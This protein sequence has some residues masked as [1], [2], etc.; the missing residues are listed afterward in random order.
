[1]G[2][3]WAIGIDVGG[4][5]I[6]AGLVGFPSGTVLERQIVS[7]EPRRGG[8]AVLDDALSMARTLLEKAAARKLEPAGIG[9]GVAELVDLGGNIT[10][11][12]NIPW[13]GLP[14]R[15]AFDLLA[16]AV[17]ESDVRAAARGEALLGAGQSFRVFAYLTVGTGISACLVQDGHPYAGARGNA[18][19]LASGTYG[20]ECPHCGAWA[21]RVLED[22]AA[23]GAL[24]ARY[25]RDSTQAEEVLAAAAAGDE[26]A[27]VVVTSAGRALGQAVG[28]LV[29]LLDPEALIVGGGLGLAGG[30]YWTSLV[31]TLRPAVWSPSTR[32]LAVLPARLGVDAGL[33]GAAAV[34]WQKQPALHGHV[35]S[36]KGVMVGGGPAKFS[37]SDAV[38]G[39][40]SAPGQLSRGV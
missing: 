34:A 7:T 16:P 23:G 11:F 28:M 31:E 38:A 26:R 1:M 6:A 21:E 35:V 30:P 19:V 25:G 24:V 29:N 10:S 12:H 5:K 8:Q 20:L 15:D 14:V 39:V 40:P 3:D 2:E 4:T 36:G 17:L 13:Q 18:I 33:I 32:E 22:Y 9:V 27:T 37:S